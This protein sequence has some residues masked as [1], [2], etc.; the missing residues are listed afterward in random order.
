VPSSTIL[1]C[2]AA[3][4]LAAFAIAG[5]GCA[6]LT[7]KPR[8]PDRQRFSTHACV[9]ALQVGA[10]DA[11]ALPS[12][13]ER[14]SGDAPSPPFSV[15]AAEIARI[16]GVAPLLLELVRQERD[17]ASEIRRVAL[18]QRI[19]D[20]ILLAV[21]DVQGVLAELDCER[22]RGEHLRS[23]LVEEQVRRNQRYTVWGALAGAATAALSGGL[24][25]VGAAVIGDVASILGGAT[26]GFIVTRGAYDDT[27]GLLETERNMLTAVWRGEETVSV[28]P[29]SVWRFL[30][31][32]TRPDQPGQTIREAL[33]AEWRTDPRVA[34]IADGKDDERQQ[35]LLFGA[36]GRYSP[37]DLQL[38][39]AL[40]DLLRARI[41][42][43]SQDLQLLFHEVA[44]V[45]EGADNARPAASAPDQS[46]EG[47]PSAVTAT[48]PRITRAQRR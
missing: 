23:G 42:L 17:G 48:R 41:W 27:S 29:P 9:R 14:R 2:G 43:M 39:D 24:P 36:G 44:V 47:H 32:G 33:L 7:E 16:I 40:F 21:L 34:G 12:G 38:R 19:N 1:R 13:D 30:T 31:V 37:E 35:P 46:G 10:R 5:A 22:A 20:R 15:R 25:L 4:L 6:G 8:L 11:R 28:F 18:R 26:E 45:E 3:G